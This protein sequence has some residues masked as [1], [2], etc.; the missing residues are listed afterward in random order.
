MEGKFTQTLRPCLVWFFSSLNFRHSSLI[1]HYSSLITLN[2]IPVWHH[3]SISITQYFSY[4]LWAPYLSLI[5]GFFFFFQYP[6]SPNLV[7][8]KKK[9]KKKPRTDWS[10]KKKK[11]KEE[12]QN[13]PK[14]KR[15]RKKK[16][17]KKSNI[18]HSE[19]KK[20]V[21]KSCDWVLF[22]GP[23]MCV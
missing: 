22:V 16:K 8:K 3:H 18:D 12:T 23:P 13:R 10:E 17:K 15:K 20:K 19:T 7:E 5:A 1:T 9:R 14:W 21:V 4:Y 2:T 11:K 6:N